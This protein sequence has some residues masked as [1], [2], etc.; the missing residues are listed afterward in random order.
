M[1]RPYIARTAM[2]TVV[3]IGKRSRCIAFA[4]TAS[5]DDDAVYGVWHDYECIEGDAWKMLW[6]LVPAFSRD[7]SSATETHTP[8][9]NLTKRRASLP[10]TYGHEVRSRAR[11]IK[12]TQ[13]DRSSFVGHAQG[14]SCRAHR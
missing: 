11:V 14:Y 2:F 12:P 5:D 7:P 4:P 8:A 9:R 1:L 6:E 3:P 10:Q 13:P